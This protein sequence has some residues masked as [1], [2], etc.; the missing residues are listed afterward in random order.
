MA[1]HLKSNE[2]LVE[3][4]Q[5]QFDDL[6]FEELFSRFLP[7]YKRNSRMIIIPDFQFDDYLQEA[8][9]TLFHA[10]KNFQV[11]ERHQ[12]LAPYYAKAYENRLLN[13]L[14]KRHAKKRCPEELLISLSEPL[15]SQSDDFSL[16]F[17]DI[18]F[19]KS[20]DM[21]DFII[22][23][24]ALEYLAE[25]L[26]PFEKKVMSLR[27]NEEAMSLTQMA[28]YLKT[29]K[30]AVENALSRCRKKCRRFFNEG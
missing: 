7:L 5:Q 9:L 18:V 24:D 29:D 22:A 21:V 28:E 4:L 8:R 10:V 3:M 14:R 11:N 30:R 13:Q 17:E 16:T 12:H 27:L 2:E 23:K 6:I 1:N 15:K 20:P 25:S 26:S 19:E